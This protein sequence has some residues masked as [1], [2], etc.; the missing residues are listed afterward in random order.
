[1]PA[2]VAMFQHTRFETEDEMNETTFPSST[3]LPQIT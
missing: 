2:I 3:S 1:M